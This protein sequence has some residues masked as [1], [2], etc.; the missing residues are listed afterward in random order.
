MLSAAVHDAAGQRDQLCAD[1]ARDGQLVVG[2]H[3]AESGG[4]TDEVVREHRA[5]EPR[6]VG[7][8][9]ARRAVRE[10][11]A[12]FEVTDRE[13]DRGVVAVELVDVD[14]RHVEAGDER[15]VTPVGPQLRLGRVDE[16]G[17]AHDE[18][19]LALVCRDRRSHRRSRRRRLHRRRGRRSVSTLLAIASMQA[20]SGVRNATVIDQPTPNRSSVSIS[21]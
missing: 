4:P 8:E 5:G 13:F 3:V 2:M 1:G 19:E 16:A 10:S 11:G 14:G 18:A 21:A 15:V 17:A 7:E 6:G 20:R 12:V 9:L